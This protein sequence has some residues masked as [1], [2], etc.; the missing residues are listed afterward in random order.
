MMKSMQLEKDPVWVKTV[1]RGRYRTMLNL[2]TCKNKVHYNDFF[3]IRRK[4]GKFAQKKGEKKEKKKE[5]SG[6]AIVTIVT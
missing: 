1:S 4:C 5:N 6:M 2:G 3:K